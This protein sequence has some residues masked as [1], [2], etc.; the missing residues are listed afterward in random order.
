MK[1]KLLLFISF[2]IILHFYYPTVSSQ[3]FFDISLLGIFN[4]FSRLEFSGIL[5]FLISF[6]IIF[7][8]Y[9]IN[10]YYRQIISFYALTVIV[11]IL[12][13]MITTIE[14]DSD[15]ND[16]IYGFNGGIIK[17]INSFLVFSSFTAIFFIYRDKTIN[18]LNLFLFISFFSSL[19]IIMPIFNVQNL[20]LGIFNIYPIQLIDFRDAYSGDIFLYSYGFRYQGF[21]SS[22][23]IQ[24]FISSVGVLIAGCRL[25]FSNLNWKNKILYIFILLFLLA[26]VFLTQT[27]TFIFGI[28]LVFLFIIFSKRS[29]LKKAAPLLLIIIPLIIY[30][31]AN[32]INTFTDVDDNVNFERSYNIESNRIDIIKNYFLANEYNLKS[33]LIGDGILYSKKIRVFRDDGE[34]M[35]AH[36]LLPDIILKYGIFFGI[37]IFNLYMYFLF[38]IYK[39]NIHYKNEVN[40]KI[41]NSIILLFFISNFITGSIHHN[42]FQA[43]IYSFILSN[44]IKT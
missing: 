32:F 21:T 34:E 22:S 38:M 19:W 24:G 29:N 41:L 37:I 1:N 3:G 43:I 7:R 25:F 30:Y 14:I 9:K 26:S 12:I 39:K 33:F 23:A 35:N 40:F 17:Y 36:A 28:P 11:L 31:S 20:D 6:K 10:K 4:F 42:D 27:R 16:L 2:V 18:F 8:L 44:Y 13:S 15:L 5:I